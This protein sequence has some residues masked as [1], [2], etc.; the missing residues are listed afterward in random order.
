M[1]RHGTIIFGLAWFIYIVLSYLLFP[2]FLGNILAPIIPLIAIGT[3]YHGRT[4]GLLLIILSVPYHAFLMSDVYGDIFIV[5]QTKAFATCLLIV[6]AFLTEKVKSLHDEIAQLHRDL[7]TAANERTSELNDRTKRLINND[8]AIR[9]RLGQDIHDGVGQYLTGLLL[10]SSSLESELRQMQSNETSRITRLVDD[11]QKNLHL[12]RKASRTLFPVKTSGIGLE[13]TI[14]ELT[15]YFS[16]TNGIQFNVQIGPCEQK[17][18]PHAQLQIYR[19]IYG[20]I[21][22]ALHHT[23]PSHILVSLSCDNHVCILIVESNGNGTHVAS[24]DDMEIQL[25]NYRLQQIKGRLRLECTDDDK[26]RVECTIPSE[27][28]TFGP[29]ND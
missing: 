19:I 10:F 3:W 5:Y 22:N 16:E 25:M 29:F 24:I 14:F 6:V 13:T 1:T 11:I 8:E 27:H 20:G 18:T 23:K 4:F 21:I 2:V 26:T 9:T 15:S 7:S 17:L 28:I 12:A